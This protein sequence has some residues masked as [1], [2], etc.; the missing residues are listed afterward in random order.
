MLA[1]ISLLALFAQAPPGRGAPLRTPKQAAPVDFTGYW[2]AVITEDWK[3]RM[4]AAN[5]GDYEGLP[6]KPSARNAANTWD[7]AKNPPAAEDCRNFGAAN[8]MRQPGRLHITWQ[9]DQ[10]LKVEM[11]AGQQTRLFYFGEPKSA[12]GDWQGVSRASWDYLPGA[13][14]DTLAFNRGAATLSGGALKVVTTNLKPGYLRKNG[15]PYSD[16]AVLTEYFDRVFEPSGDSFIILTSTLEDPTYLTGPYM[17]S[18]HFK[19]QADAAGWN[20]TPCTAR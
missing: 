17:I 8:L 11:D 9:D 14:V 20:P 5:K 3:Y 15:V 1:L 7:P 4:L 12:G 19:K 10:T 2:V 13:V 18:T 6:L 16:K